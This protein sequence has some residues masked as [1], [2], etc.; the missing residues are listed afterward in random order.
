MMVEIEVLPV[1][2]LSMILNHKDLNGWGGVLRLV[3]RR[4]CSIVKS[5]IIYIPNVYLTVTL[6]ERAT[7]VY[8]QK[9]WKKNEI[10]KNAAKVGSIEM[11]KWA[12]TEGLP[13]TK[14]ACYWAVANGHLECLKYLHENGCPWDKQESLR[15]AKYNKNSAC[16]EFIKNT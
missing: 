2:I 9:Q 11:I 10:I 6:Y 16:Y 13:F 3:C 7:E 15:V 4:W 8:V 1:E 5:R 14:W 12:R